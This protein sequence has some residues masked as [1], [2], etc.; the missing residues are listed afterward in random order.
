MSTQSN[1]P[2]C[3]GKLDI[4]FPMQKDGL[5]QTPE[6]CMACSLKTDCLRA[7]IKDRQGLTV[8]QE[9]V[10]RAYASGRMGFLKRWSMKKNLA[11]K[12]R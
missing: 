6:S 11:Q 9:I 10:D 1:L 12:K 4:V 8:K 7:A 2:E 3:Y 5:R